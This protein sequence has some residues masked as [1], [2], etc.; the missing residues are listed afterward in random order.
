MIS[1]QRTGRFEA[2]DPYVCEIADRRDS[3]QV[4]HKSILLL[5]SPFLLAQ[6][7]STFVNDLDTNV[8]YR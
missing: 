2:Y 3:L 1:R 8:T 6:C 4:I 5:V 7:F